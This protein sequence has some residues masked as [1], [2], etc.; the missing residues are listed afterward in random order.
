MDAFVGL[1]LFLYIRLASSWVRCWRQ[2][3]VFL[4]VLQ[5]YCSF[6]GETDF[7]HG[8]SDIYFF[9]PALSVQL[10]VPFKQEFKIPALQST[11]PQMVDLFDITDFICLW[12]AAHSPFKF[13][14]TF[15]QYLPNFQPWLSMYMICTMFLSISV[16][17]SALPIPE[18]IK[19][20]AKMRR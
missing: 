13:P 3:R 17:F 10:H 9:I 16:A 2:K 14:F 6:Q 15:S 8:T 5:I 7:T 20:V 1:G 18:V 11:K 19:I 12:N 4:Y